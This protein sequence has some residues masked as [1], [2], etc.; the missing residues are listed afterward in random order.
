MDDALCIRRAQ[1]TLA[2]AAA[3]SAVE[4]VSLRDS[5]YAPSEICEILQRVEHYAYLACVGGGVVGF[6]SCLETPHRSGWRL[7]IDMLGVKP[8]FRGRGV[9]THLLCYA[10]RDAARRGLAAVRAVV[11]KDNAASRRAF[12]KAGLSIVPDPRTGAKSPRDMPVYA[13]R[14]NTARPFL[15]PGWTWHSARDSVF[16]GPA[17]GTGTSLSP[18][19]GAWVGWLEDGAGHRAA[20]AE[21]LDVQTLSYRGVWVERVWSHRDDAVRYLALGLVEHAKS[22]GLD[23]IGFLRPQ[24]GTERERLAWIRSGYEQRGAYYELGMPG[25]R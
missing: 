13:P 1:P 20:A 7:D 6:C 2:D 14:G 24:S 12:A 25:G 22:Q 10:I 5:D 19:R 21:C 11:A 9:A 8:A 3:L 17:P 15:Q 4:R 16:A 23:E 18:G